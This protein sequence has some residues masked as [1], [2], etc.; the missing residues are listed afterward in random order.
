M[1]RNLA[2]IHKSSNINC[3]FVLFVYVG[4]VGGRT[5]APVEVGSSSHYLLNI[6]KVSYIPGGCLGFL[7]H[8]QYHVTT[9]SPQS[10]GGDNPENVDDNNFALLKELVG[11]CVEVALDVSK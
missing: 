2:K 7:N 3:V 4:T 6:Y 11:T 5:P 8:Q 9:S 10:Q 1:M